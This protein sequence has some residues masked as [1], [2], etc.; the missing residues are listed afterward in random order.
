MLIEFRVKNFRSFKAETVLSMVAS[1]DKALRESNVLQTGIR[2]LPGL[3][4]AAGLYGANASGKSNLV[5]AMQLL[6]GIVADSANLQPNQDIN[7]QPFRLDERSKVEPCEFE[8]SFLNKSTRYQ[9]SFSLTPKRIVHEKLVAYRT[10]KPQLWYERSLK[11]D[12]SGYEYTFGKALLGQKSTWESATKSNSLFLSTA[13]QLNSDQLRDPFDWLTS[14]FVIENGGVPPPGHTISYIQQNSQ[15]EITNFLAE[16]DFGISDVEIRSQKGVMQSLK[17]DIATGKMNNSQEETD[18]HVPVFSHRVR[19][20]LEK[21]D[22]G[23]ESEGTRKVF[24]L[25]GP[26]LETIKNG[27]VVIIDELDRSLHTLLVRR[28]IN[29]F[30]EPALNSAGAQIIFTTHDTALLSADLLRRDQLWFTEKNSDQESILY[31]LTEFAPRKHEALEN[32]YLSGRYGAIPI[33]EP[34]P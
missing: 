2:S 7:V 29:M 11:A 32:G 15:R 20:H 3:V 19:E 8:I 10:A 22:F 1:G 34:S 21:F 27:R 18:F 23:D 31:P 9:F 6:R 14:M 13:V 4:R 33:L 26:L 24:A 17:I 16:A 25:A 5:R 30:Q 28:L 12:E